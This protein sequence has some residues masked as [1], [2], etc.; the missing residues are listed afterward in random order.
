MGRGKIGLWA[1]GG[2][3]CP[4][5]MRAETV[6]PREPLGGVVPLLTGMLAGSRQSN[7]FHGDEIF[8]KQAGIFLWGN[9]YFS[10]EVSQKLVNDPGKMGFVT[11]LQFPGNQ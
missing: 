6:M 7:T 2:K 9:L 8:R 1:N 10:A 4:T 11:R 5:M 3:I